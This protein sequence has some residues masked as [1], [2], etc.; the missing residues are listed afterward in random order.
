MLTARQ[1]MSTE[2]VIAPEGQAVHEVLAQL[3]ERKARLALVVDADG[4]L[5]GGASERALAARID[6]EPAAAEGPVSAVMSPEPLVVTGDARLSGLVEQMLADERRM[7]PVVDEA[8][9][10]LGAVSAFD[11]LR[12]LHGIKA[13]EGAGPYLGVERVLVPI[14]ND[15]LGLLALRLVA[16]LFKGSEVHALHVVGVAPSMVPS[17]IMTKVKP[18]AHVQQSRDGLLK[19]IAA[20]GVEPMPEVVVRLGSPADEVVE[21]AEAHDIRLIVMPSRERHGMRRVLLGSTAEHVVRHAHCP[22]LVLRGTLPA[23]WQADIAHLEA[24]GA[25]RAERGGGHG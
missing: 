14:G 20:A 10:V 24:L 8:R 11:V 12:A 17:A 23:L 21:Y 4:A 7:V 15:D 22:T 9:R 2:V 19:R 16:K 18:G 6:A 13:D 3:R 25:K 1:V 5:V